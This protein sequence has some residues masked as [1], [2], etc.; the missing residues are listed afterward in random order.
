MDQPLHRKAARTLL[1]ALQA[2][3]GQQQKAVYGGPALALGGQRGPEATALVTD[4]RAWTDRVDPGR[5][6]G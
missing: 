4:R 2:T 1:Q 5:L 6:C 3:M